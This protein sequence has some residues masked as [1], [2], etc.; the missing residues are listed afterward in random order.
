MVR[1]SRIR[2]NMQGRD[3]KCVHDFNRRPEFKGPG[4][5]LGRW[6]DGIKMGLRE[7]RREVVDW[8]HVAHNSDERLALVH[9]VITFEFHK[10]QEM[11]LLTGRLLN[12]GYAPRS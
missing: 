12:S 9:T 7:I 5:P 11:C 10:T 4:R 6:E 8:I 3:E 2:D 1:S